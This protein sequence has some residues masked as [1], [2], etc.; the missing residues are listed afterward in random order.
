VRLC[1]CFEQSDGNGVKQNQAL[2]TSLEIRG[3]RQAV[4]GRA[5]TQ[6]TKSHH[7][8]NQ[9]GRQ[10]QS[11]FVASQAGQQKAHKNDAIRCRPHAQDAQQQEAVVCQGLV[12]GTPSLQGPS[13]GH[14]KMIGIGVLNNSDMV[15]VWSTLLAANQAML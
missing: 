6:H 12:G 13:L 7:R 1:P 9:G 2:P 14:H 4:L 3:K 11:W 8:S 10:A 15:V 5:S